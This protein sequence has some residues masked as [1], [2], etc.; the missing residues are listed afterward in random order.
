VA[1]KLIQTYSITTDTDTAELGRASARIQ[2][3]GL[4]SPGTRSRYFN[5]AFDVPRA[6]RLRHWVSFD[7]FDFSSGA[8][9]IVTESLRYIEKEIERVAI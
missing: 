9:P 8:E 7:A 3:E 6:A 1:I 2:Q 4:V 5:P